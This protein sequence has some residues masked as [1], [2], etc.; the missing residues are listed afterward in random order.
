[1]RVLSPVLHL[2]QFNCFRV[3]CCSYNLLDTLPAE[4]GNLSTLTVLGL[5]HNRLE[6]LPRQIATMVLLPKLPLPF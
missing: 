5:H 6:K 4:I 1:M 2:A 3:A